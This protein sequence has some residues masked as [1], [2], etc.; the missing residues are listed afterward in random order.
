MV[1]IAFAALAGWACGGGDDGDVDLPSGGEAD[2]SDELHDEFPDDFPIY[3]GADLEASYTGESQGVE[4]LVA[5]WTTGD[6]I[7]EVRTFFDDEFD[8][9]GP[10]DAQGDIQTG[11]STI[12]NVS[13]DNGDVAVVTAVEEDGETSISVILSDELRDLPTDDGDDD[14]SDG[15]DGS[16]DSSDDSSDDEGSD[17]G[18]GD[19]PDAV[20]LPDDFPSGDVP[21]PDD[22][23]ITNATSFTTSGVTSYVVEFLSQDSTDDLATHFRD[24]FAGMGWDQ[25]FQQE[26][27][28]TITA[29]YT[30]NQDATGSV[31]SV[32]IYES[33]YDGYNTVALSIVNQ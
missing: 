23:R 17:S 8:G 25:A 9:D 26:A 7:D 10:W 5:T 33:S 2:I 12:W 20:D 15:D 1:L 21:L 28:G 16:D 24:A 14:G 30:E 3:D 11:D 19:L 18:A 29:S 32:T 22:I 31:V 27:A 6:S 13:N 4:G